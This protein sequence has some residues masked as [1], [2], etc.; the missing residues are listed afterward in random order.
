MAVAG[1]AFVQV[2]PSYFMPEA[3]MPYSQASGAFDVLPSGGPLVRLS[4]GDL[5]AYIKRIDIRTKMAEH[6]GIDTSDFSGYSPHYGDGGALE[7]RRIALTMDQVNEFGPP[8]NPAKLT[9][10]RAARYVAKHGENS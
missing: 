1:G 10:P 2:H 3:L 9:D 4:D 7:V 5:Y 8:P 6:C